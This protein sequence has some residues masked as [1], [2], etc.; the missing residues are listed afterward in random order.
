MMLVNLAVVASALIL[1]LREAE[2]FAGIKAIPRNTPTFAPRYHFHRTPSSKL[3][4]ALG[5]FTVELQKPLG[6]ILQERDND[7]G[8]VQVKELVEGGAAAQQTIIVPGDVLLQVN[9]NDVSTL[10]FDSVMD[11]LISI[12]ESSP[13]ILTLGD[14]L[15]QLDMPKNVQKL[16]KTTEEAFFVDRVVRQ[17]VREIRKRASKLGDL[18]KV[19][20][21]IGAG[22]QDEGRRGQVRFFAIFSTGGASSYSCNVSATGV[23]KEDGESIEIVSLSAAKDE[24]LGQT[25]EFI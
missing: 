22:V 7:Y 8:G 3:S 18:L 10:D 4:M 20:V 16:L 12:D 23:Q 6:I 2:A 19:E 17:A 11:L 15:G 9:G 25:I 5:D 24:G 1:S 21:I 14:G 13:A